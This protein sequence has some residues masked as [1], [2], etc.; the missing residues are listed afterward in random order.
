MKKLVLL[1]VFFS[2]IFLSHQAQHQHT[3]K[4]DS[5]K[6]GT[7]KSHMNGS[8]DINK[9]IFSSI[10]TPKFH[11]SNLKWVPQFTSHN[12][13][14]SPLISLRFFKMQ[15]AIF[16]SRSGHFAIPPGL[17]PLVKPFVTAKLYCFS[18]VKMA[19]QAKFPEQ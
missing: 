17:I 18:L 11:T 14:D 1:S 19:G 8:I 13:W 2:F 4:K 10:I 15:D 16:R 12:N 9:A 5:S 7:E 3:E 6:A